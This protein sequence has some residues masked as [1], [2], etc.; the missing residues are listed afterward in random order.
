MEIPPVTRTRLISAMMCAP[1]ARGQR[2]LQP[3]RRWH[4]LD[5]GTESG[6]REQGTG[7]AGF[8]AFDL[9]PERRPRQ[10]LGDRTLLDDA[11]AVHD[12]DSVAGPLHL[13]E[14]VGGQHDGAALGHHRE[15]HVAH[16]SHSGRVEPVHR[17]VQKEQ[18][19]VCQQAR[20]NPQPLA[21]SHR[22]FRDPV[23]ATVGQADALQR[24]PDAVRRGRFACRGEKPQVLPACEM[25]MEPGFVDDGANTSERRVAMLRDRVSEQGHRASIGAGQSQQHPDE[26]GLAGAVG[27]EVAERRSPGDLELNTV[28]GKFRPETLGEPVGLHGP[29]ALGGQLAGGVRDS[30]GVHP[31]SPPAAASG[32]LAE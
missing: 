2:D 19:G 6:A 5:A 32:G 7:P 22:V 15:D 29:A 25:A 21:H 24:W 28:H 23:V 13:V 8:G 14:E 31:V 3:Q 12:G 18:L 4:G 9:K 26:G 27:A 30:R 1:G 10:Q 16:L 11:A 17:L 20:G